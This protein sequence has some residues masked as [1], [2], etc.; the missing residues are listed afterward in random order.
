MVTI[1]CSLFMLIDWQDL[2]HFEHLQSTEISRLDLNPRPTSSQMIWYA[3]SRSAANRNRY[4]HRR[5]KHFHRK[6]HSI[7]SRHGRRLIRCGI[8]TELH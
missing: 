4:W 5:Y 8:Y 3:R 6:K 2:L 1:C 7:P